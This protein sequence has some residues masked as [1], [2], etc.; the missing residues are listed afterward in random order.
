MAAGERL[1]CASEYTVTIH[2]QGG[3][4]VYTYVDRVET[5]EWSRERRK[6][7]EATVTIAASGISETCAARLL[8]LHEWIHEVTVYRDGR[9]VW[10]GPIIDKTITVSG[11]QPIRITLVARDV[12]KWLEHR[13]LRTTSKLTDTDLS[14]VGRAVVESALAVRDPNIAD[15]VVARPSGRSVDH[16]ISAYTRMGLDELGDVAAQGVDWTCVGRSIFFNAVAGQDTAPQG[17]ITGD[18]L[19]GEVDIESSGEDYASLVYAAPQAQNEVWQHLEGVGGASPYYGLVEYVVQTSLPYNLDDN[20]DFDPQ[21]E[22][23]LNQAQTEAA[24]KRAAQARHTQMS[25]PPLVL[26]TPDGARL[27]P[28]APVSID[29]LVPGARLDLAIAGR[30][31]LRVQ[32]AMRLTRVKVT[33]GAN[34]EEVGVSLVQIGGPEDREELEEP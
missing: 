13:I 18:D 19:I 24:L 20:G 26:R 23:G 30:S 28:S 9:A 25:R 16:T 22:D 10:Q 29:R 32:Q 5:L 6:I 1:G 34:G 33:W 8:S 15:H 4:R 12:A 21:G 17:R 11:S 2:Y 14:E 27:A 3:Q 7:S 31:P